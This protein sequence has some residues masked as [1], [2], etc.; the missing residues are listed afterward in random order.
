MDHVAILSKKT[1][2]LSKIISGEKTIESRWYR[3]KKTPYDVIK[4]DDIVYFKESGEPVTTVSDVSKVLFFENLDQ[5]KIIKILKQYGTGIG[6]L[7]SYASM[8]KSK[9]Y[10][11]LIFLKNVKEIEPFQVNKTG[12]GMMSAWISV[13]DINKI[14]RKA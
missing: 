13:D 5:E 3:F 11:T 2:W 9:N 8:L 10:C 1:K 6:V 7:V 14:K 4:K 12:F